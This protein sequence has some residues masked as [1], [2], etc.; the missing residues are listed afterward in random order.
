MFSR[1]KEKLVDKVSITSYGDV[2][3]MLTIHSGDDSKFINE[4]IYD[5]SIA[6]DIAKSLI[7]SPF[8]S[9]CM[10]LVSKIVEVVK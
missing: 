2:L 10:D 5:L 7:E 9:P 6:R 4:K 8:D 1:K 3:Y